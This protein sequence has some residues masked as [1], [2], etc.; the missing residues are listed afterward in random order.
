MNTILIGA[1]QIFCAELTAHDPWTWRE[2]C[3]HILE[4]IDYS[5]PATLVANQT[6]TRITATMKDGRQ[7]EMSNS[8]DGWAVK[9]ESHAKADATIRSGQHG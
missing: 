4:D 9:W 3:R 1:L 6:S 2:Q 8:F 5:A 7:I